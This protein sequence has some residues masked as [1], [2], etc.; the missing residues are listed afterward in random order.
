MNKFWH[1]YKIY[2]ENTSPW[3]SECSF[4]NVSPHWVSCW[5]ELW[6]SESSKTHDLGRRNE[7][8]SEKGMCSKFRHF[9]KV[10]NITVKKFIAII[11]PFLCFVVSFS[12]RDLKP[13]FLYSFSGKPCHKLHNS[14]REVFKTQNWKAFIRQGYA[15]DFCLGEKISFVKVGWGVEGHLNPW[16]FN[17]WL[18]NHDGVEKFIVEKCGKL[19]GWNVL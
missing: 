6:V 13:N 9:L 10:F 7:T 4:R 16:L 11:Y 3:K 14:R 2:C 19:W 18:F 1:E 15:N 8:S 17:P 5:L 12:Y